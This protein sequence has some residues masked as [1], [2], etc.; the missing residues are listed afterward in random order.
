MQNRENIIIDLD[1]DS[2]DY[3]ELWGVDTTERY[4]FYYDESNNCRKFWLKQNNG[5]AQF[6]VDVN[7]DFILAGVAFEGDSLAITTEDL[8]KKLRLQ[9]N[10]KEIK[11]KNHFSDYNFLS[12][13]TKKR[14]KVLLEWII[15]NKLYVHYFHVNNLYYA[16]VEIIDS[17]TTPN[18][19]EEYGFDYFSVKNTFYK[20]FKK[21]KMELERIMYK[22]CFPNIK[23]SDIGYFCKELLQLIG[24]KFKLNI[25]EKFIYGML[26]R[27][28]NGKELIF[29]QN[30]EDYVMQKNYLEFYIDPIT[31]FINSEHIFD[32]ELEIE[33]L[34]EKYTF[35]KNGKKVLN[36]KFV[37]SEKEV[38]I[39]ISD[40]I[41]GI[42]G[43][44]L[45]YIN[46]CDMNMLRNDVDKLN[47]FQIENILLLNRLRNEADYK[48]KGFIHSI[49]SQYEIEK[50]NDFLKLVR[51][52]MC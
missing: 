25:E 12:C 45:S 1:D 22:Y 26:E 27:A 6:N 42:F 20:M 18:E 46:S 32:E 47:T 29:I 24:N 33:K 52:K 13:M 9:A 37:N 50:L 15:E 49:T 28:K 7:E 5:D 3:F 38:L 31:T 30:N 44:L 17:I 51:M 40:V 19:I 34:L 8:R 16:L 35:V 48:N 21:K 11:F 23:N 4:H 10:V 14:V 36:Y 41:A 2:T 39:Q 43:K